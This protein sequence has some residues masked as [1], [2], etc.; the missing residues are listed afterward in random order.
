MRGRVK[1]RVRVRV[2][3]R[4]LALALALALTQPQPARG[5]SREDLAGAAGVAVTAVGRHHPARGKKVSK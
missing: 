1:I 3:V 2:E 5:S 4:T